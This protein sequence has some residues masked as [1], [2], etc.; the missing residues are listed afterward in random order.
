V[1]PPELSADTEAALELT[2][3]VKDGTCAELGSYLDK[4]PGTFAS[5]AR[6]R[7]AA[8]EESE[9]APDAISA[10]VAADELDLAF[11]NS[12]KDSNRR[13]ELPVYLINYLINIPMAILQPW[14]EHGCPHQ[15]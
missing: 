14:P 7:I 3:W 1:A 13:E 9:G 2:F 8:A 5:L 15:T 12:V 4:F 10:E 6:T 11:W